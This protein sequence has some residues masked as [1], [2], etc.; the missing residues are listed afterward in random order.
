MV[1][2]IEL[3]NTDK[4]NQNSAATRSSSKSTI[5]MDAVA[6][7]G[8]SRDYDRPF[9]SASPNFQAPFRIYIA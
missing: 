9:P 5:Q 1:S 4:T 7:H 2:L 6:M 3:P 8:V